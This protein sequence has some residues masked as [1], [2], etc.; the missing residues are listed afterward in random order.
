M[1]SYQ[2]DPGHIAAILN[3]YAACSCMSL[4]ADQLV[5]I[6]EILSHENTASWNHGSP[7]KDEHVEVTA[8]HLAEAG[9]ASPLDAL[10]LLNRFEYQCDAHP[11]WSAS[12]ARGF[13]V[14]L[15]SIFTHSL[16]CG[17]SAPQGW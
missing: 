7:V 8:E 5:E 11:A 17:V 6:A 16:P 2:V 13:C 12:E 4:T 9:A 14:R 15:R 3:A 1:S 10:K